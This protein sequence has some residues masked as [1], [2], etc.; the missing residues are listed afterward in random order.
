[1]LAFRHSAED[2]SDERLLQTEE[3]ALIFGLE[4]ATAFR[5][6]VE[7]PFSSRYVS[8]FMIGSMLDNQSLLQTTAHDTFRRELGLTDDIPLVSEP[9]RQLAV[10]SVA[11]Y[12]MKIINRYSGH[13]IEA[14]YQVHN[15]GTA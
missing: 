7:D 5:A 9:Y 6:Y 3:E 12:G 13:V 15:L 10:A 1:M 2:Q 4:R 14:R 8:R 11:L